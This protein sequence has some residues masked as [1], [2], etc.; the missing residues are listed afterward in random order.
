MAISADQTWKDNNPNAGKEGM[1]AARSIGLLSYR[2]YSTYE[3]TQTHLVDETLPETWKAAAYQQYQGKK[4]A[5]RFNAFSYTHLSQ[6]M[7]S[8]HVGRGRN[9]I[10]NALKT[11]TAN[12]L[13][14]GIGSDFLFPVEEQNLLANSIPYAEY[15][16]ID[17]MYGHDGFLIEV[18]KIGSLM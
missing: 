8:H 11:I 4:L 13:V 5:L 12:T 14:I 18:E 15:K 17:S 2:N 7:D 6:T 16:E 1:K 10:E 3:K 9:G